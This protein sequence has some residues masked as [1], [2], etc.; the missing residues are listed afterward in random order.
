MTQRIAGRRPR[1]ESPLGLSGGAF[2]NLSHRLRYLRAGYLASM[3]AELHGVD[4]LPATR[5]LLAAFHPVLFHEAAAQA[6]VPVPPMHVVDDEKELVRLPVPCRLIPAHPHTWEAHDARTIAGARRIWR[7][8]SMGG[9]LPAVH[10]PLPGRTFSFRAFLGMTLARGREN[11]AWQLWERFRVPLVTVYG[12]T[13]SPDDAAA[14][15]HGATNGGD[16]APAW[17]TH[18]EPLPLH[19]LTERDLRFF[20][21]VSERPYSG[22]TWTA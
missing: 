15:D 5:D 2:V 6:G 12:V 17:V 14:T 4:A 21:E 9:G 13:E 10:Y 19:E 3:D 8:V 22:A 1:H 18:I 16:A 11:L 7:T 20:E